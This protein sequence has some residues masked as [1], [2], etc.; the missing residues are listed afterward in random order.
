[1]STRSRPHAARTLARVAATVAVAAAAFVGTVAAAPAAFAHDELVRTDPA[2][3]ATLE[4]LP[5]VVTLT[6]AEAP[7]GA[8]GATLVEVLGPAGAA[9]QQG[10]PAVEGDVVAQ[11]LKAGIAAAGTYSVR[12]KVVSADGHPV[13]GEFSFTVAGA[14]AAI[15]P[16]PTS[17]AV[18]S[19]PTS[20]AGGVP[21]WLVAAIGVVAVGA[22]GAVVY[23]LV[24]RARQA[25]DTSGRTASGGQP[26]GR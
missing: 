22:F 13:S 14:S 8:P 25:A 23:L 18:T 5:P 15:A 20:N 16:S 24:A 9:V 26:G 12:F 4:R 19:A 10:A 7:D 2:N 17:S 21:G 3:G 1:M 6:F 11:R